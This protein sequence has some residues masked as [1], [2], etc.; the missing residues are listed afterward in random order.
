MTKDEAK[1]KILDLKYEIKELEKFIKKPEVKVKNLFVDIKNYSDVCKELKLKE[2]TTKDF[3]FL[4][5]DQQEKALAFHQIKNIETLFNGDWKKDW[6][7]R[8]QVK[9]YPY[10]E[11]KVTG[12]WVFLSSSEYYYYSLGQVAFY[13]DKITSDFCGRTFIEIYKKLF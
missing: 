13:K 4:P 2:L 12:G 9:Y 5:K 1:Q 8:N 11:N 3:D 6:N 10:F 7:N